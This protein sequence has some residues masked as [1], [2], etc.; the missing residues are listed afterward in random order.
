MIFLKYLRRT[1]CR[2][3]WLRPCP[4]LK[5]RQDLIHKPA[6]TF[7][8]NDLSGRE[9]ALEKYRGK[10]VLL[11]FWATWCAGC[12]VELPK[13]QAWHKK[14]GA[15]GFEVLAVSMD[16]DAAPVRKTVRQVAA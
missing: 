9:I 10:V 16:D 13:F 11:D 8:R 3:C 4:A 12:Q 5:R 7:A 2:L 15:Q 6:P 1:I 14:Y